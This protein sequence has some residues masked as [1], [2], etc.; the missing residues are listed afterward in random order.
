MNKNFLIAGATLAFA[1]SGVLAQPYLAGAVGASRYDVD[2]AGTTA[3]DKTDTGA[4][5]HLGFRS[6]SGWA[7]ELSYFHFGDLSGAVDVGG[8]PVSASG[9]GTGYGIGVAYF[10]DFSPSWDGVVR[11]GAARNKAKLTAS[12]G[13]VSLADSE[14]STQPYV[15]IGVGYKLTPALAVDAGLDFGRFDYADETI[16]VR[17]LSIGLRYAF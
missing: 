17:L 14:S 5:L 13:A 7:A 9:K 11:V 2:C 16:K 15:G 10:A 4:K 6:G 12:S 1:S 8:V 3:C